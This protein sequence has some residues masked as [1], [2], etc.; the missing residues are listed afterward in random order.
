[1]GRRKKEKT[2]EEITKD[3][4]KLLDEVEENKKPVA[5][6]VLKRLLFMLKTLRELEEIVNEEGAVFESTNGNGFTMTMEHPA[7]K[8]YNTMIG[9]YNALVKTFTELLPKDGSV[10]DALTDFLND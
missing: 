8:S 6:S 7:Q 3:F 10:G 5:E 9:R 2:F 4:E 1:M